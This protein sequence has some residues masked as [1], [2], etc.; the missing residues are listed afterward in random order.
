M[1]DTVDAMPGNWENAASDVIRVLEGSAGSMAGMMADE[2]KGVIKEARLNVQQLT[3][4]AGT[5][6]RCNVDFLGSKAGA[7]LQEFIGKSIIGKIRN[8]ISRKPVEN[9]VPIPWVCQII[10]DQVALIQVGNQLYF[11]EG[12]ITL[13][14][15]N[16]TDQNSP[17]AYVVDEAGNRVESIKI[18]PYRASPYQIQLNLQGLDFSSVPARSRIVFSWPN[19]PETSGI[20]ILQPGVE[21]P[22]AAF[23]MT[24]SSGSA[25]LTV[26]FNDQSSND[27]TK[28]NWIFGDGATSNERNPVHTFE[29]A[30]S[31]TVQLTV[32]NAL[33]SSTVSE[34]LNI[35]AQLSADFNFTPRNGTAPMIVD[36]TDR[37]SGNPTSWLWNFGDGNISTEQNPRYVY[38]VPN[39][40]GYSVTLTVSGDQGSQTKISADRVIVKEK[41]TAD[42]S[43]DLTNGI[44]P[45][46]VYFQ[47]LSTG[48]GIVSWQWDFGDGTTSNEPNPSHT[49]STANVYD[50]KLTVTNNEG[51]SNSEVKSGYVYANLLFYNFRP[52]VVQ[53]FQNSNAYFHQYNLMGNTQ[54]DSGV[55]TDNYVCGIVGYQALNGDIEEHGRGDIIQAYMFQQY[56]PSKGKNTW[57]IFAD[58]RSHNTHENWVIDTLCLERSVENQ[59][60]IYRDNIRGVNGGELYTTDISTQD[61]FFCGI[62]GFQALNGDIQEVGTHEV[63][64]RARMDNSSAKWKIESDFVSHNTNEKW[65][66]N[67]LCLTRGSHLL[68]ENPVFYSNKYHIPSAAGHSYGTGISADDYICGITGF[69]AEYGDIN[70]K[71]VQ[72]ILVLHMQPKHSVWYINADFA[73]HS[74]DEDWYVHVLCIRRTMAKEGMPP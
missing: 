56:S 5:E 58:F 14:G 64:F 8:I 6:F 47:D 33:G 3:A 40:S 30:R 15:Y 62:V 19:V 43:S 1:L 74:N 26:M 46:T 73:S 16:Y 9:N 12:L 2:I 18:F 31:Y 48:T 25:P 53:I 69:S 71:G 41:L 59:S 4:T 36:F 68:S 22:V 13:T 55:P 66:I 11:E 7:T 72:N 38:S 61:Y 65:N 20:A 10:P 60:F 67:L 52:L 21:T 24:P 23:S 70:E 37:S 17:T 50:V 29:Q 57:W 42:F 49:F 35:G 39:P 51:E 34:I 63:M 32:T 27:P 45:F 44:V 28:W 54:L